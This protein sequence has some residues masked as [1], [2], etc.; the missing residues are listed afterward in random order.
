MKKWSC[1]WGHYHNKSL[2][3]PPLSAVLQKRLF[4]FSFLF[5]CLVLS[6]Y[7]HFGVCASMKLLIRPP[8][9]FLCEV[10]NDYNISCDRSCSQHSC[11]YLD[12]FNSG[13]SPF[14]TFS[15]RCLSV[16]ALRALH[17]S[18]DSSRKLI[19]MS[20]FGDRESS[21]FVGISCLHPSSPMIQLLLS[22]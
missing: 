5:F 4:S 1:V 7:F 18:L 2:L 22:F 13:F 21:L 12:D 15:W 20:G 16:S 11:K 17:V 8:C 9:C 14:A 3:I 10:Q 6:I 19:S